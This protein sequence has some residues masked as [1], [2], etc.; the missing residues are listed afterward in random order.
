M[1]VVGGKEEAEKM[2]GVGETEGVC[3]EICTNKL[4]L[5]II[6]QGGARVNGAG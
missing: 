5:A 2:V 4:L 6:L 1:E 3:A